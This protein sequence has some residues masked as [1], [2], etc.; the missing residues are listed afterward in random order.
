MQAAEIYFGAPAQE[1]G[2]G[3]TVEIGVFVNTQGESVNAFEGAVTYS[4]D[5]LRFKE[6]LDGNSIVSL[7]IERPA[8]STEGAVTFSGIIP[9]GY[10]GEQGYLFSLVLETRQAGEAVIATTDDRILL[11]DGFGAEA[12]LRRSPL[13]LTVS[14]EAPL[15][16]FLL[17]FDEDPP[18][19]FTPVVS[20]DPNIFDGAWFVAFTTADKGSGI[21]HYEVRESRRLFGLFRIGDWRGAESPTVLKD[22]SR[23]SQVSVKAVDKAGHEQIATLPPPYPLPWYE[24]PEF[25]GIIIG[26]ALALIILRRLWRKQRKPR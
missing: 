1:V 5:T 12:A 8:L 19:P 18:E 23:R 26:L 21:D 3:A 4:A 24:R 25:L 9:G 16:P 15:P 17:P 13:T 7:W 10:N 22:Q 2:V 14:E 6:V 20:Q 11:N